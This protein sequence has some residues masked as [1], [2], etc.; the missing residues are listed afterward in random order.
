MSEIVDKSNLKKQDKAVK[1]AFKSV[2]G[3]FLLVVGFVFKYV[4]G[5]RPTFYD[6]TENDMGPYVAILSQIALF[7]MF[8]H[9]YQLFKKINIHKAGIF[10]TPKVDYKAKY[11]SWCIVTGATSGLGL[12]YVNEMVLEHKMN[13][14][15]IG[16]REKTLTDIIKDLKSKLPSNSDEVK[17]EFLLNDFSDLKKKDQFLSALETKMGFMTTDGG[18]GMLINCVGTSPRVSDLTHNTTRPDLNDMLAVNADTA[19]MMIQACLPHFLSRKSGA[20]INVASASGL[21]PTPYLSVYSAT[22]AFDFQLV[23]SCHYE[24]KAEGIDFLSVNPYYFVSK[25]FNK[26]ETRMC[27]QPEKIVKGSL[28]LLGHQS[29]CYPYTPH[30]IFGFIANNFYEWMPINLEF[31]KKIREEELV[32]EAE[33]AMEK[34]LKT[35]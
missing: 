27:P 19:L 13:V 26:P 4:I 6:T 35:K 12:S 17:I 30:A 21:Q 34:K 9:G 1:A 11:G 3:P 14:L 16:R 15:L 25:M 31:M 22:K 10:G 28:P 32:F 5:L 23:R 24:Y 2:Y 20:V 8:W 7:A 29:S 18:L 33:W